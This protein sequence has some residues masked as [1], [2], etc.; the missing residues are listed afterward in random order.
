MNKPGRRATRGLFKEYS[1]VGTESLTDWRRRFVACLDPTEYAGAIELVGS[2][3][4]WMRFKRE[5]VRFSRDILPEWLAEVEIK[6]RSQGI[7]EVVVDA[8]S[9]SKSAATSARWLAEAKFVRRPAGK[10]SKAEVERQAKIEAGVMDEVAEDIA[11]VS[12]VR[13]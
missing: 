7:R 4:E 12:Q 1:D 11:R 9:T 8:T 3:E 13:H 10:P 6:L 2:W 5:W